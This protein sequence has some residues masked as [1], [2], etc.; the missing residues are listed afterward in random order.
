[1]NIFLYYF[2]MIILYKNKNI[3]LSQ[4]MDAR[5][6]DDSCYSIKFYISL[7]YKI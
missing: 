5:K 7:A 6:Y 1:M 4:L 2:F 3:K